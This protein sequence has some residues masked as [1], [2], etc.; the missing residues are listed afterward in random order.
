MEIKVC[1]LKLKKSGSETIVLNLGSQSIKFGLAS[2]F[3]PFIMPNVI[4][5][6]KKKE[7]SNNLINIDQENIFS[8][9]NNEEFLNC[10]QQL[11]QNTLKKIYKMDL[12]NNKMKKGIVSSGNSKTSTKVIIFII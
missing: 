11:E 2:Q 6:L 12:K 3:Q 1:K 5:Y 7:D 4:A 10:F 9:E 8:S